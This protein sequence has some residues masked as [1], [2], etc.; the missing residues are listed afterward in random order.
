[1]CILPTL[2]FSPVDAEV[3]NAAGPLRIYEHGEANAP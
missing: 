1:M 3:C 2:A